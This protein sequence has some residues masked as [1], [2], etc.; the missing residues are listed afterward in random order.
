[1]RLRD[2]TFPSRAAGWALGT[3]EL[4]GVSVLYRTINGDNVPGIAWHRLART[5]QVSL[6]TVRFVDED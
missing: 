1:V 2:V 3:A 4:P 5:P 6:S